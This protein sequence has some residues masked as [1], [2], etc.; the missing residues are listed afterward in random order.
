MREH[1]HLLFKFLWNNGS[2]A[3][4]GVLSC[5][6]NFALPRRANPAAVMLW[7]FLGDLIEANADAVVGRAGISRNRLRLNIPAADFIRF[8]NS[9]GNCGAKSLAR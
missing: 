6:L 4:I 2:N 7:V 5:W 1:C 3:I 8:A 9:F